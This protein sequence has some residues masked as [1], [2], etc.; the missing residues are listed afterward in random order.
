M[1]SAGKAFFAIATKTGQTKIDTTATILEAYGL[2]MYKGWSE[3]LLRAFVGSGFIHHARCVLIGEFLASDATHLFW[4]DDDVSAQDGAIQKF[5]EAP[6]DFIAA[7][8]PVRDDTNRRYPIKFLDDKEPELDP[9]TGLMKVRNVPFGFACIKRD[10]LER[11]C[12]LHAEKWFR[13]EK[14][15]GYAL[16]DL[17]WMSNHSG[18]Q[19]EDYSFCDRWR[20]AGM[21][22]WLDPK[23][24]V[25]HWGEKKY[26]GMLWEDLQVMK[27]QD[28]ATKIH[29]A[30]AA[31]P[32]WPRNLPRNAQQNPIEHKWLGRHL[33]GCEAILEI[34]SCIG[35]NLMA[36]SKYLVKGAKI[37]AIDLGKVQMGGDFETAGF[38][39]ETISELKK[40]GFDAECFISDSTAPEAVAWAQAQ[41][42]FDFVYI[43]GD[44]SYDGVSADF[45]NYGLLAPKVGFHDIGHQEHGVVKFWNELVKKY[46]TEEMVASNMGT[47]IVFQ[48][49]LPLFREAAE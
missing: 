22:V 46:P 43:D 28:T 31:E 3:P 39:K 38:L 47:G 33:A 17:P 15:I 41:G 11:L 12:E 5:L 48:D 9:V 10:A 25:G 8:Y 40:Q 14:V 21:D 18:V 16:M 23:I 36:M 7:T 13:F 19:G 34:G 30:L 27:P 20:E 32:A 35:A 4:M 29:E 45:R 42:P 2:M 1:A 6:V 37:R 26:E 24:R 44:H 49:Q